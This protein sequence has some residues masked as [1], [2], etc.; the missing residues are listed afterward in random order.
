MLLFP[1]HE[2]FQGPRNHVRNSSFW[3]EVS[4]A[5]TKSPLKYKWTLSVFSSGGLQSKL[6]VSKIDL[7]TK[8]SLAM[9][10]SNYSGAT[11]VEF[12][13]LNLAVF[14]VL[15]LVWT[16]WVNNR[17]KTFFVDC[18][19]NSVIF[20]VFQMH[21]KQEQECAKRSFNTSFGSW[22][23]QKWLHFII[24]VRTLHFAFNY[25]E[26]WIGWKWM[27]QSKNQR[28]I[29]TLKTHLVVLLRRKP[30]AEVL[31]SSVA[32][33]IMMSSTWG[34][35]PMRVMG[36]SQI[37]PDTCWTTRTVEHL[38]TSTQTHINI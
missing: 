21:W 7:G 17:N 20:K 27:K 12:A 8:K 9:V 15:F 33:M 24:E 11:G 23:S 16:K 5:G 18:F 31:P 36:N 19:I 2:L 37:W 30:T 35:M 6:S 28:Q 10:L 38:N 26:T 14:T 13:L 4:T 3:W 1:P 34:S 32:S 22:N 29:F 25:L